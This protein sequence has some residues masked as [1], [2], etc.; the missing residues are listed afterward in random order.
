MVSLKAW[1]DI[2][3]HGIWPYHIRNGITDAISEEHKTIYARRRVP[4]CRYAIPDEVVHRPC[5]ACC[6]QQVF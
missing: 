4:L 3:G 6:R 2:I 1:F 5:P